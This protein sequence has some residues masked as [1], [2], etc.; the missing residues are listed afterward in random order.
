MQILKQYSS[1]NPT[2]LFFPMRNKYLSLALCS[3]LAFCAASCTGADAQLSS[4]DRELI[5]DLGFDENVIAKL[6]IFGESFER[7]VGTTADFQSVP[8][9]G[10]VLLTAPDRGRD[11]LGVVRGALRDSAYYAY[12]NQES[13]GYGPDKIAIVKTHDEYDYLAMVRT[14]GINYDL[15]HED[16]LAQYRRWDES[17]GLSLTGAGLDWLEAEFDSPPDNWLAFA[18]EVYEFCPDIVDQGAGSVKSLVAE[19][20]RTNTLYLWWD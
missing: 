10:L 8:V 19:M 13:F 7:L 15:E 18:Q 6:R 17:L 11:I 4:E 20:R 3:I 14:D 9:D 1:L 16:V 5:A 2:A 12:L